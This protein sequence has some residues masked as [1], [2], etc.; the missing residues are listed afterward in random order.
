MKEAVGNVETLETINMI[1]TKVGI[2]GTFALLMFVVSV[3]VWRFANWRITALEQ[4]GVADDQ[5]QSMLTQAI[6]K[7]S[8]AY[9]RTAEMY[10]KNTDAL[11]ALVNVI[12]KMQPAINANTGAIAEVVDMVSTKSDHIVT[13]LRDA[14][15]AQTETI[16]RDVNTGNQTLHNNLSQLRNTILEQTGEQLLLIQTID[17]NLRDM[18]D[19]QSSDDLQHRAAAGQSDDTSDSGGNQASI[20]ASS[21]SDINSAAGCSPTESGDDV[22]VGTGIPE[23]GA[24]IPSGI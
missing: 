8:E 22:S 1:L 20:T 21:G 18:I 11:S 16:L 9:T 5:Q 17:D 23:P 10:G 13:S 6:L 15:D 14:L 24:S 3:Q 7:F 12:N 2:P 19:G 4:R